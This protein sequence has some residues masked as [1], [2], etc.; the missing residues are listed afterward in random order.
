MLFASKQSFNPLRGKYI[1]R[2]ISA[3]YLFLLL[4]ISPWSAE[5]LVTTACI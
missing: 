5:G 2:T 4:G 3:G 1:Q